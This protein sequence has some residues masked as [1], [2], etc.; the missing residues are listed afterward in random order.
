MTSVII[1][2]A[3]LVSFLSFC[4]T[5]FLFA[6]L[7]LGVAIK[8]ATSFSWQGKSQVAG[9]CYHRGGRLSKLSLRYSSSTNIRTCTSLLSTYGILPLRTFSRIMRLG[10]F[11]LKGFSS[12][13]PRTPWNPFTKFLLSAPS[14]QPLQLSSQ[15]QYQ[16]QA[17]TK[18]S[19]PTL[20]S[21]GDFLLGN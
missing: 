16:D 7:S 14:R 19:P 12:R 15:Q 6:Y 13:A 4:H 17:S 5:V 20:H 1:P 9:V 10:P 21:L 11:G 8:G 3:L 18:K 2:V